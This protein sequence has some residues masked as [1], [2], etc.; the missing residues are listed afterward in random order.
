MWAE[1][2][3]TLGFMKKQFQR[4]VARPYKQ[5]GALVQLWGELVP[6]ELAEHTR[7]EAVRRG[8]LQVVVDSSARLYQLDR[9]LRGGLARKLIRDPRGGGVHRIKLR[10]GVVG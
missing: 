10:L 1:P 4:D 3:L 6:G 7:L 8:V 2:D 9:E 5:L